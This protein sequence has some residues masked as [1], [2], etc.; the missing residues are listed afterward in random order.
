MSEEAFLILIGIVILMISLY[1]ETRKQL[2]LRHKQKCN[3]LEI[4]I[5][6]AKFQ[7]ELRNKG[8]NKYNFQTF[9]LSDSLKVQS[10]IKLN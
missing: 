8:L 9:N 3:S 2:V 10:E 5:E 6:R 1:F 7:L 4:E